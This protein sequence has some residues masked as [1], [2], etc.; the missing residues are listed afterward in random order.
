MRDEA[1]RST[2][3]TEESKEGGMIPTENIWKDFDDWYKS[4]W[5]DFSRIDQEIDRR[6]KEY[7]DFMFKNRQM[8]LEDIKRDQKPQIKAAGAQGTSQEVARKPGE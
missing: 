3:Q 2:K 8:Q 1:Q 4:I 5:S 6:F 7:S